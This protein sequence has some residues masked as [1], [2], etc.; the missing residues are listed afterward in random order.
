ML[1]IPEIDLR[2][3]RCVRLTDG[4][5]EDEKVFFVDPVRMARLWR[6]MNAR[7]LHVVDTDGVRDNRALI[8]AIVRALDIPVEVGGG[9]ATLDDA[10]ELLDMGVYRVVLPETIAGGEDLIAEA[11]GRFGSTRVVVGI[12]PAESGEGAAEAGER[13]ARLEA[14]GVKRFLYADYGDAGTLAGPD[15]LAYRVLADHL[16]KARV[17]AGGVAGYRDLLALNALGPPVDSVIV[18]RA[19]YENRFPCQQFW[20][21]HEKETLDLESFSTA[22]LADPAK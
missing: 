9:I 8:G 19:L 18:G 16:T 14:R 3:G 4:R 1:V 7:V 2:R 21:W 11:V 5:Y 13:A 10:G 20:A 12:H 22:P 17:T 15:L 6:V